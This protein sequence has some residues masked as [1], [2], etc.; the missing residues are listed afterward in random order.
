V[1]ASAGSQPAFARPS[2]LIPGATGA[3]LLIAGGVCLGLASDAHDRLVNPR[4]DISGLDAHVA[5]GKT[6]NALGVAGLALSAASFGIATAF[7]FSGSDAPASPTASFV[8]TPDGFAAA[9]S[10]GLPW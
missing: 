5:R 10:G 1:S 7:A 2:V 4:E 3:A 8:I 6:L 9:I